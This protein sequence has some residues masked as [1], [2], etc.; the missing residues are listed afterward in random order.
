MSQLQSVEESPRALARGVLLVSA[1]LALAGAGIGLIA[2]LRGAVAGEEIV[3]VASGF[4]VSVTVLVVSIV[5]PKI[6]VQPIAAASTAFYIVY[7]CAG[8]LISV[9]CKGDHQSLFVYLIWF[10]PLLL[11]NRLVNSIAIGKI[12]SRVILFAP[13]VTLCCISFKLIQLFAASSLYLTV[14]FCLSYGFF[15]VMLSLITRYREAYIIER[16]HAESLRLESEV[17]ESISDC[18]ISLDSQFRLVYLNDAACTE[19]GVERQPALNGILPNVIPG[20]FSDSMLAG[21]RAASLKPLASVFE[22]ECENR[23]QWYE[24]RC[25]PRPGR[26]SVY[27]RNITESV[28][29]R[30][31]LEAAHTRLREQSELLDKA[32]DAIFV[33]DMDSCLLYWNKGAERLFG[34]SAAE[35]LG[36]FVGQVFNQNAFEIR[37]AFNSVLEHGEWTCELSKCHKDGRT[38]IVESRN[39]LLRGEDGRPRSILSIN[40]DITDRKAA[41]VRIHNLA[42]YDV[43]TGLPNRALLRERLERTLT[44]PDREKMGALLLIDLDDFKTLNDTSGHD[45]GDLLLQEVGM[46]LTSCVRKTDSVARSG[47]DEFVVMLDG[48][49]ADAETAVA[50]AKAVGEKILRACRQPCLLGNYE[51]DGTTSIGATLIEGNQDTVDALLKRVD[52]AMYRAK[53]QGRNTLCF[54]DP[55]ME[56]GAASHAALLAD[57][58]RAIQNREFELHYQPQLDKN[59]KV[60]GAEALLRWRHAHRGMV[61]PNEFIPMAEAAGLIGDLGNWVLETACAQLAQ[62]ATQTEMADLDVAVNV[63]LR[64]FLDSRFV[65]LVEKVLRDSGANPLRLKLEITESFMMDKAA[66]TIAKMTALKAH[67]VGFSMDDFGTGYSSLSQ[68]KNLPLDQLKID[69]SFVRDV[70]NG[71]RDASIVRTIITLGR[72]LNLS[73]IAEGVETEGQREFLEVHGCLAYQGYLFSPALPAARFKSFVEESHRLKEEIV[74]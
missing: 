63:S 31:N 23:S 39:T 43:L 67:G 11:F 14:I 48:L 28:M 68:L 66:E 49:S 24:L 33:Q 18:F 60:T 61:P 58:K 57:L 64:Q 12:L 7:L 59:G 35:V 56:T 20:F 37:A 50:E 4:L 74:A 2:I 21:L 52:L 8:I 36:Q 62:W 72:S 29:S 40:T 55:A 26:M 54:F 71:V 42:F 73:V 70:L 38:F 5:F 47:G 9:Y 19:L 13:L 46:R 65:Q 51:Y 15:G 30:R 32:Q 17:L 41:D 44:A 34:W 25:F 1:I 27:F 69:Q 6:P 45:I 53:A 3:L 22:A 10:Y 16:A